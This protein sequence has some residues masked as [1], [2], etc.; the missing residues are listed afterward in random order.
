MIVNLSETALQKVYEVPPSPSGSLS[1][2]ISLLLLSVADVA[3]LTCNMLVFR[4]AFCCGAK[5][6]Q[7]VNDLIISIRYMFSC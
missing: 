7:V 2:L 5:R 3:D 4:F 1:L 6:S